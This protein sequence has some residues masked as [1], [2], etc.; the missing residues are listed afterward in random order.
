M[1]SIWLESGEAVADHQEFRFK[2]LKQSISVKS[3]YLAK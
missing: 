1:K 3:S 2:V